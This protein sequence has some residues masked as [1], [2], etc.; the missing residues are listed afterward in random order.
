MKFIRCKF[1]LGGGLGIVVQQKHQQAQTLQ[2]SS[3]QD[4]LQQTLAWLD[5]M[6]KQTKLDT[7]SWTSIQDVRGKLLKQK[8]SLQEIV[9][10][11]RVVDGKSRILLLQLLFS[12]HTLFK[13]ITEKATSLIKLISNKDQVSDIENNVKSIN[14]RYDSLLST[15]QSNI[16][17]LETCLDSYQQFYD[18]LKAQQDNQKQLWDTLN[19]YVDY[20]GNK[21]IVEER[22]AKVNEIEDSL[23]EVGIKLKELENYIK[24]NISMLP[25]RAQEAM[26]RDVASLKADEDKFHGTLVDVK[27]AL[28]NRLKQWNDYENAMERLLAFLK[29]S[30]QTLKSYLPRSTEE[31]K[32]EQLEK[33]QVSSVRWELDNTTVLG[34]IQY[35]V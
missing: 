17:Q 14:E 24:N 6:E 8:T 11:K 26:Q 28:E 5:T 22:L 15:T 30:E 19:C 12:I 20:S 23:T 25:A 9:P 16:K 7:S 34:N 2:L 27:S 21:P 29:E 32:K 4:M 13:G 1:D 18:L 35:Y 3:Y 10:Y 31:E 33:Y